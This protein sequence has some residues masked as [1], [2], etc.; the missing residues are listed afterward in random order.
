MLS[1][2]I[3]SSLYNLKTYCL[4]C[5]KN[6]VNISSKKVIVS[7]KVIREKSKCANCVAE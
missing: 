7:N 6:T 5:R 1:K 3:L 2:I 4:S